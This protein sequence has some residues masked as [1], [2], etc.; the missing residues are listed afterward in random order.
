MSWGERFTAPA[1][2]DAEDRL[3]W[4]HCWL[5]LGRP[6][7]APGQWRGFTH[8]RHGVLLTRDA[9][10]ALH[11][12][13]D[14]CP[15]RGTLLCGEDRG[16]GPI[17]CPYHGW[18]FAA[19]GQPLRG[20]APLSPMALTER[21]GLAWVSPGAPD[22]ASLAPLD[23]LLSHL[24]DW[25]V[26]AELTVALRCNWKL[27]VEVHLEGLHLPTL[28]AEIADRV[29]WAGARAEAIGPHGVM[30]VPPKDPRIGAN[31]LVQLFPN[32]QINLHPE[33]ALIFRHRPHPT[34][35]ERCWFDQTALVRAP[36]Q[37]PPHAS[38]AI[39][40]PRIGPITAADLRIAER[41]AAGL[42]GG[43]PARPAWTEAELL[44]RRFHEAIEARV[45]P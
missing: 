40:D 6:Q 25:H 1:W 5:L 18:T 12:F 26:S 22:P 29:D 42:R 19:D 32:V 10:G 43:G 38:V 23:P 20:D 17:R 16:E 31:T 27:S 11:A 41:L 36:Q 9:A 24:A 21:W 35:P 4:P 37:A 39:D 33:Q 28:H 15:H 34:D 7:L 3:L 13:R 30:R 2:L 45:Q 44:V 14:S 8:G